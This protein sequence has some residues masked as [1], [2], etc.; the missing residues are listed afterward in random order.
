M[1]TA[2]DWA[3]VP[4]LNFAV[5][6]THTSDAPTGGQGLICHQVILPVRQGDITYREPRQAAS[7]H[8]MLRMRASVIVWIAR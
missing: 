7:T 1:D 3:S 4:I 5:E 8:P 2:A 6:G